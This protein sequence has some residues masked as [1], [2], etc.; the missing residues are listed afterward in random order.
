MYTIQTISKKVKL[1]PKSELK[2]TTLKRNKTLNSLN[3]TSLN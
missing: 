1:T 3:C 2:R